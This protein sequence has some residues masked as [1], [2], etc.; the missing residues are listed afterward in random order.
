MVNAVADP[1]TGLGLIG[2]LGTIVQVDEALIG[3]RK[4]HRARRMPGLW[5]LGM[6]DA[7]GELRLEICPSRSAKALEEI[8][9][10]HVLPGSEI[11]TDGWPGYRGLANLG[12]THR[13]VNHSVEFVACDGT[14]TQ[15]IESGWRALRRVFTRGGRR[16]GDLDENLLSYLWRRRCRHDKVDPFAAMVRL[17]RV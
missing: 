15:Q 7:S 14:H 1:E 16:L 10:R 8:I 9:Q 17:L 11:H 2:G 6:I 5:V 3:R 12:F 13:V 4:W